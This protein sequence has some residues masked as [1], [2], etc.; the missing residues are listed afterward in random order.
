MVK[1]NFYPVHV[2]IV[3]VAAFKTHM[4]LDPRKIINSPFGLNLAFLIGKYTPYWLGHRIASFTAD[5]ISAR[6][7]W[8][9]VRAVRCNQWIVHGEDLDQATLDKL[10]A[11]N[12][13]RIAT[14]IF[15]YYHNINNPAASLRML[16]PHPFAVQLVQRP[17]F[18]DRGLIVA[19]VHMS[20]FDMAFQVGGLAGVK[21]YVI[22]LPEFNAAY[23]KQWELRKKGGLNF[24]LA[25]IGSIKH[26]VEHLKAGG[27]VIS[28][29]DRPDQNSS[30]RPKFFGRPAAMPIHHIFMALKAHVPIIVATILKQSDGKYHFLFSD[31]IE[32]QSHPDRRTETVL[33]AENVLHVAEEYI[34]HDSI[35]WAMTFPVWP[36]AMNQVPE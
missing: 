5:R 28:A 6:R 27:M 2:K 18:A 8:K 30:Y 4:T 24:E 3:A 15:D 31:P 7:S 21:A 9:L 33:N 16:E 10:V 25:S 23:Q 12:F 34:R 17:E 19:G 36:E 29:V 20:N 22:T 32:M 14:S 13:R 11:D 35:Q 1:V 26:A